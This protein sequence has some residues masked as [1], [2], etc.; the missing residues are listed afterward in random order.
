MGVERVLVQ[1]NLSDQWLTVSTGITQRDSRLPVWKHSSVA[2]MNHD[3]MLYRYHRNQL[4]VAMD[5]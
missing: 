2:N 3:R 1:V 5:T 4:H